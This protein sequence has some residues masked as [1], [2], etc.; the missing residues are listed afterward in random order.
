MVAATVRAS[1]SAS[2]TGS[3]R[4]SWRLRGTLANKIYIPLE[5]L[6]HVQLVR[7]IN[8]NQYSQSFFTISIA[9]IADESWRYLASLA[10][11]V[12]PANLATLACM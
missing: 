7:H 1:S 5:P 11:K 12:A 2:A 4:L 8:H 3:R 10:L 9:K 6:P